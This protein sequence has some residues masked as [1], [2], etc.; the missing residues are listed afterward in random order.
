MR[1]SKDAEKTKTCRQDIKNNNFEYIGN[2]VFAWFP[3][4][5]FRSLRKISKKPYGILNTDQSK[6]VKAK[7]PQKGIE[8]ILRLQKT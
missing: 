5:F 6:Q 7:K 8:W 3:F 2:C 1:N 4:C